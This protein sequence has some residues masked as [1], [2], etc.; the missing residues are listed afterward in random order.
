MNK[1][2]L[3]IGLLILTVIIGACAQLESQNNS[4]TQTTDNQNI[5]IP[6][7]NTTE[8]IINNAGS[9]G[10]EDII[11]MPSTCV[12]LGGKWIDN[13]S[14]CEGIS[15][16]NCTALDG[17]FDECASACRHNPNPQTICT[18]QCV[19]VCSFD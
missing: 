2:I 13:Y 7:N 15:Q 19:I 4:D 16:D 11:D 10:T 17:K 6:S 1:N 5:E 9:D 3:F 12:S 14:E 18:M 8:N